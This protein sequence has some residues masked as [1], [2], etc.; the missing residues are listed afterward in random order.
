MI[1]ANEKNKKTR[2]GKLKTIKQ[3]LY[4][5]M[6]RCPLMIPSSSFISFTSFE[7][8]LPFLLFCQIKV[9]FW[10]PKMGGADNERVLRSKK[11]HF[12][13]FFVIL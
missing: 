11:R 9:E 13:R 6:I 3:Q 2:N 4:D 7:R 8:D 5:N 10:T 1:I 12:S